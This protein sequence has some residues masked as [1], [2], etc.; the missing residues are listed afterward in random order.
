MP[1]QCCTAPSPGRITLVNGA[2]Q[3]NKPNGDAYGVP[4]AADNPDYPGACEPWPRPAGSKIEIRDTEDGVPHVAP[5]EIAAIPQAHEVPPTRTNRVHPRHAPAL[6]MRDQLVNIGGN[7]TSQ[8]RTSH[9]AAKRA[10]KLTARQMSDSSFLDPKVY[11][12]LDCT[13][14]DYDPCQWG[15]ICDDGS[16]DSEDGSGNGGDGG[17]SGGNTVTTIPPMTTSMPATTTK[18]PASTTE[19]TSSNCK[20]CM[21][22]VGTPVSCSFVNGC[23]LTTPTALPS[24]PPPPP[25]PPSTP[26][27]LQQ[28]SS[29]NKG[30]GLCISLSDSSAKDNDGQNIW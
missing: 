19:S 27:A 17:G 20:V 14:D 28:T 29:N 8:R 7:I 25:P 21:G 16:D 5:V 26:P 24:L 18:P 9:K 12:Y 11:T 23:T 22:V 1:P 4:K 2:F 10:N 13:F 6:R 3:I 15:E 30:S